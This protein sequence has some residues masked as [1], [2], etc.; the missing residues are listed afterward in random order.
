[1]KIRE[2]LLY[3][4]ASRHPEILAWASDRAVRHVTPAVVLAEWR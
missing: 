1:M 2:E 4:E 3:T